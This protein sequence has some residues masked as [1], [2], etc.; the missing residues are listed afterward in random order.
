[1]IPKIPLSTLRNVYKTLVADGRGGTDKCPR[2]KAQSLA[3]GH[4]P[5]NHLKYKKHKT[6]KSITHKL[7]TL[8][9]AAGT[10]AVTATG[11]SAAPDTNG[12]QANDL[13]LYFRNPAGSVNNDRVIAFSL[14]STWDVFRR[15]ATPGDPTFNTVISLGNINSFLSSSTATGGYGSD[16]TSLSST[17]WVGAAGNNGSTSS[18]GTLTSNQDYARTIYTTKPRSG[19]GSYGTANSSALTALP[20]TT[21]AQGSVAG[22]VAGI[23]GPFVGVMTNDTPVSLP[24]ANSTIDDQNPIS[25]GIAG[26]AYNSLYTGGVMGKISSSTYTYG[27][28]SNVVIGLD[29]FRQTP[30][31]NS[32]GWQNINGISD[33]TA[34][35]PYYLGTIT[36]SSDGDVNFAAVPEPSTY[37]L[38][39]LA[40][41]GLGAH[42]IRRRKRQA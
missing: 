7:R 24:N 34:R 12:Y 29:L 41:A 39:A 6:M 14:G 30:V 3:K 36:L 1:M 22:A 26:A 21:T 11:S 25:S 15:A 23:G 8:V 9:L 33:V 19:A 20:S 35:N 38:L 16:W 32:D 2:F 28:I 31:L 10:L 18:G 13:L 40:A 42:I 27:S 5:N 37:A 4:Y 17:I